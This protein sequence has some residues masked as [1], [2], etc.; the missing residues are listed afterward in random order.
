MKKTFR[1]RFEQHSI[2]Y[3]TS[4]LVAANL[5]IFVVLFLMERLLRG[6]FVISGALTLALL[7]MLSV[8]YW[9]YKRQGRK[10]RRLSDMI[11]DDLFLMSFSLSFITVGLLVLIAMIVLNMQGM[12]L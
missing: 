5:F 10:I 9:R 8:P 7:I 4:V 3:V 2:L 12:D 11:R 1:E 6:D